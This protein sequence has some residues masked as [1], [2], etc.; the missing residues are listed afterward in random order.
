MLSAERVHERLFY[1]A[2]LR[3][4]GTISSR[5]LVLRSLPP[6]E[7]GKQVCM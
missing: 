7:A 2:F 1:G 6:E 5:R 3:F 4:L